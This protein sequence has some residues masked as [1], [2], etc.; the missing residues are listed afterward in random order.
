MTPTVTVTIAL[1]NGAEV[2]HAE[3]VSAALTP[4]VPAPPELDAD[5][6]ALSGGVADIPPPADNDGVAE[7]SGFGPVPAPPDG[8]GAVSGPDA[9]NTIAPPPDVSAAGGPVTGILPAPPGSAGE[10]VG[11]EPASEDFPPPP[12]D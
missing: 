1:G 8:D 11:F 7:A 12:E 2:T 10:D 5:D 9:D 6:G 3:S 4:A